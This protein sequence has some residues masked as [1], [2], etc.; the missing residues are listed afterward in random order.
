MATNLLN[1][2]Q[3]ITFAD[4]HKKKKKVNA[5]LRLNIENANKIKTVRNVIVV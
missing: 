1:S 4:N 2:K 3:L 5:T